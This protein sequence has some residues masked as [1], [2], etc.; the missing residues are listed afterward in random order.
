MKTPELT[1]YFDG[2]C[3]FCLAGMTRL[4]AWN[5]AGKLGF[6]DIS[7]ASFDPT[8]LGVDMAALDR[9]LHSRTDD[10]RVLVGID[11]MLQAYTLLG[12]SWLVLPLRV[13]FLRPSL[14]YLYQQFARHRYTFSRLLG[15]QPVNTC[16]S[17]SCKLQHPFFQAKR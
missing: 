13:K 3:P 8:F 11:S 6:V 16:S 12:K 17:A 7:E 15:Y 9:Q 2:N 4:K 14:S 5:H 10:G 1:L